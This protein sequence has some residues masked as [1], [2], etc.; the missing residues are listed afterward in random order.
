VRGGCLVGGACAGGGR[1]I[2]GWGGRGGAWG[3]G[4]HEAWVGLWDLFFFVARRGVS[5]NALRGIVRMRAGARGCCRLSTSRIFYGC[6][7]AFG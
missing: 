4:V 1:S 7:F 5:G 3:G 6:I 2:E